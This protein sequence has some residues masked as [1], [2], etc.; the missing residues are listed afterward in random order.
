MG[1]GDIETVPKMGQT[2]ETLEQLIAQWNANRLDLFAICQPDEVIEQNKN[3]IYSD[4][5]TLI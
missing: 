3:K 4:F 1:T 2:R 5:Y